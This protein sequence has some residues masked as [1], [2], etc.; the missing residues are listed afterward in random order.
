MEN[1]QRCSL[2]FLKVLDACLRTGELKGHSEEINMSQ[3]EKHFQC[4]IY[5]FP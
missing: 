4:L 1:L 2:Y 3:V 5:S